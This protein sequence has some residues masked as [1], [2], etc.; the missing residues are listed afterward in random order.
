MTVNPISDQDLIML[1]LG[2][3]ERA[4]E[5][6][7]LRHKQKIYG[8]ISSSKSIASILTYSEQK[9]LSPANTIK[10]N[11]NSFRESKGY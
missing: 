2:G 9:I 4:F 11:S 5:E 1:Y 8:S 3:S 6:L 10:L 7:L